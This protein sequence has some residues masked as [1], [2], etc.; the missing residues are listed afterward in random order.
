[1][2]GGALV[3]HVQEGLSLTTNEKFLESGVGGGDNNGF[4]GRVCFG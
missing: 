2:V 3:E 4:F 1:M